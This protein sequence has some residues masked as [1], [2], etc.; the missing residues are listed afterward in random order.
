MLHDS[1]GNA[2][3]P[4]PPI[5]YLARKLDRRL[6][7]WLPVLNE[8]KKNE[9]ESGYAICALYPRRMKGIEGGV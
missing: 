6:R 8:W 3:S 7:S 1:A 5:L 4:P 9:K 2:A